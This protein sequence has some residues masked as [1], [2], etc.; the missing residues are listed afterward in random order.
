MEGMK[1]EEETKQKISEEVLEEQEK[2]K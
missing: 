1:M 2:I